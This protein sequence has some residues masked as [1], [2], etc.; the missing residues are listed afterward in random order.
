[1]S[2]ARVITLLLYLPKS[3][4]HHMRHNMV[5]ININHVRIDHCILSVAYYNYGHLCDLVMFSRLSIFFNGLHISV[6]THI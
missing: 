1:M 2:L 3:L 4:V 6:Y 5:Y